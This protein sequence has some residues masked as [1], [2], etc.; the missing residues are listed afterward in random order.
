VN[1]SRR[2]WWLAT[3]LAVFLA[4]LA[5]VPRVLRQHSL[6]GMLVLASGYLGDP[7]RPQEVA[8]LLRR[9]ARPSTRG[10]K[11]YSALFWASKSGSTPVV[12]LLLEA[13]ADPSDPES[14]SPAL[15]G[16]ASYGHPHVVS[17]LLS[18]GADPNLRDRYGET[19][20]QAAQSEGH[21]A[22]V[23]LLKQAGRARR[24]PYRSEEA[25]S[26]RSVLKEHGPR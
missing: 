16:A 14:W 22:I 18:Y 17:L 7:P 11:D 19:A 15:I 26:P 2:L 3:A 4:A 10:A 1:G 20:L 6:D 9:G 23:A 21:I 25:R 8:D 12:K 5:W 13:G 24:P